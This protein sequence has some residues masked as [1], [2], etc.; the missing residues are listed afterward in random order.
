MANS[1]KV[2]PEQSDAPVQFVMGTGKFHEKDVLVDKNVG[3]NV[4]TRDMMINFCCC[5]ICVPYTYCYGVTI[6]CFRY[7]YGSCCNLLCCNQCCRSQK[8]DCTFP[9]WCFS[10]G[11]VPLCPCFC[12]I[13]NPCAQ[14]F[15]TSW[16]RIGQIKEIKEKKEEVELFK[17][18]IKPS[19]VIQGYV[20]DCWLLAA[21]AALAENPETI[22]ALFIDKT[23]QASGVYRIKLFH[24]PSQSWRVVEVDT[25]VPTMQ[26]TCCCG[27][28]KLIQSPLSASTKESE[29]WPLLLEK[30]FAKHCGSYNALT[31]G[32]PQWAFEAM[33]GQ[34]A[35]AYSR[36]DEDK[37]LFEEGKDEEK[38][39]SD[40]DAA[41]DEKKVWWH[42]ARMAYPHLARRGDAFMEETGIK[43]THDGLFARLK[44]WDQ[45]KMIMCACTNSGNDSDKKEGIHQGH[46]YTILRVVEMEGFKLVCI[47]NPHGKSEWEGDWSDKSGLW[48]ENPKVAQACNVDPKAPKDDGLFWIPFAEFVKRYNNVS[49]VKPCIEEIPP[50]EGEGC[51]TPV[52]RCCAESCQFWCL[53]RGLQ[54]SC[55]CC[56]GE[57]AACNE[58]RDYCCCCCCPCCA[59]CRPLT[60]QGVTLNYVQPKPSQMTMG[61]VT[62]TEVS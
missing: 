17:N 35:V 42:E 37:P 32:L 28:L 26:V 41:G 33:T 49:A 13:L 46:A 24:A 18:G 40:K 1:Y 2:F 7:T 52:G 56:I 51:C 11:N 60:K 3:R 25:Y 29:M 50:L 23:E 10:L 55:M 38:S 4:L 48:N 19:D 12:C 45:A 54:K 6:P 34:P 59:P 14:F 15:M 21:M 44:A 39:K 53:C 47:R 31:G 27:L 8:V 30:A 58:I 16:Q 57:K 36:R 5:P 43:A 61:P 20:G 62:V 9:P 22:K